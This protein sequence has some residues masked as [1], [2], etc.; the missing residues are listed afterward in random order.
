M[1]TP[2]YNPKNPNNV[3]P[4]I[5]PPPGVLPNF[6][7]PDTLWRWDV[8][9]MTVCLFF[10]TVPFVLR[11]YVR[12]FI[13]REWVLEDCEYFRNCYTYEKPVPMIAMQI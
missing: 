3:T 6:V 8:L 2:S 1:A 10:T 9:C 11:C 5:A 12:M 7:D 13:K 4:A